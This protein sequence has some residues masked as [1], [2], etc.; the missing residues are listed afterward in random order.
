VLDPDG[1]GRFAQ[2][3]VLDPDVTRRFGQFRVLDPDV[4]GRFAQVQ[5]SLLATV[6]GGGDP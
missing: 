1:M 2:F 4:M 5:R 6:G 3:R